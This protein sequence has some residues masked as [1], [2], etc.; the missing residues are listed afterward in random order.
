MKINYTTKLEKR[1]CQEQK[2]MH[3]H[4]VADIEEFVSSLRNLL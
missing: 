1:S 3:V 2:A 4:Y